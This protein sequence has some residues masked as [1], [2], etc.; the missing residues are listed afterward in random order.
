MTD[1]AAKQSTLN[2]V[3]L[4]AF[5]QLP[6]QIAQ[7]A[8]LQD[9]QL[10]TPEGLAHLLDYTEG[11]T[12]RN[13][14]QARQLAHF[15]ETVAAECAV[16][17][18]VPRAQYLRAQS[19]AINGE[20]TVALELVE[21]AHQGFLHLHLP[22]EALR[23]NI[24]RMR[25][26]GELGQ[27]G[28]AL[29]A[30]QQVLDWLNQTTSA[31]AV[32]PVAEAL[33][34]RALV[35]TQLGICYGQLGRFQ[36]ALTAFSETE[37]F[38]EALALPAH[39]AAA[40]NNRG[41][42]LVYLG[43]AREAQVAFV[44]AAQ[45]QADEG[46]TLPQAHTQSN[47]GEA[48][49]LLGDYR[50]ALAAFEQ[51]DRLLAN[52]D[53]LTDRQINWRQMADAYL[54]LNLFD[55]ALAT[56]RTIE[57]HL[58]QAGMV[59]ERAW[60]LWG[61]GAALAGQEQLTAAG[62]WLTAA[63]DAFAAVE[64]APLLAGV[65]LEQAAL[66]ERL[67]DNAGA[68]Q[69]AQQ[70]LDLVRAGQWPV[71][72]FLTHLRLADLAFPDVLA[73][74]EQLNAAQAL[75]AELA[76]PYLRH[77]LDQ[78]LARLY[79]LQGSTAE[80]LALL[81]TTVTSIETLRNTL[82]LEPMRLS[83][84]R[85]KLSVYELLVQL[86]LAQGDEE[87]VRRAFAV[88]ERARSRTLVERMAGLLATE[89][90]SAAAPAVADRLRTLQ[91]DLHAIYSRLLQQTVNE[92]ST[93]ERSASVA[94]LQASAIALEQEI[95]RLQLQVAPQVATP[96]ELTA[97]SVSANRFNAVGDDVVAGGIL[98][99]Y[100]LLEEEIIAFV[101]VDA[102]L[103]VVRGL[104][105]RTAVEARLQR[106]GMQWER[107]R[108]GSAFVQRHL[109]TLHQ[110]TQRILQELYQDL[111]APIATLLAAQLPAISQ[112]RA[113]TIVP[114]ALLYR[115]PFQALSDGQQTLLD[116]YV[117]AYAPS[118][119]ALLLLQQRQAVGSGPAVVVGVADPGIP[120]VHLEVQRV[121]AHLTEPAVQLDEA[122]TVPALLAQLP[123]VALLHLACHGIFR[124]DNPMFSALKL[125]DGW[126]TA[127]TVA[128]LRLRCA[129]VV[130]SA[131]E[132]GRGQSS[133]G[134]E[135]LGLARAFLGAGAA[136]LIVS[137]W[138]VQDATT[139]EL[140]DHFYG[141]L[142]AGHGAAVALRLA[143][144]AVKAHYPHPYYWA[145]FVLLGERSTG[146]AAYATP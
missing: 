8:A 137:Q 58:A 131:C 37:T 45:L 83:F 77:R 92:A 2:D 97:L 71:Q 21:A 49:L 73:V 20:L 143:Q 6:D 30:G 119:T 80:A 63:A 59:H 96:A 123:S 5:F 82:P 62:A 111:F 42:I 18:L 105:T 138:M 32:L 76:L 88:A 116:H 1:G 85:D 142:A 128:Q 67:G 81:E 99:A 27:F 23:T 101:L 57:P 29:V 39:N 146:L 33:T 145:P 74:T 95:N 70:A 41:L 47:L 132:S 66:L 14:G 140:M 55:E 90:T 139:A 60:V 52:Q 87:G 15:C 106:L 12:H 48:H 107:F 11:L 89:I 51:A 125:T 122:A 26:L 38:Y 110:S 72:Q 118:A 46:L 94:T 22:M 130:L 134:D 50:A 115:V 19:Y 102:Q 61:M 56:Y 109:A 68:R 113:L 98:V 127:A 144:L 36:E 91:A 79:L 93:A 40:K 69:A 112:P 75:A 126:L 13:P 103:H 43:R 44:A 9:A 136:T 133:G 24:G 64:N 78:R 84:L 4:T 121:A 129:L 25:V 114:H 135:L 104:G 16:P 10:L 108:A 117:I 124:A 86:Y 100:Y 31:A 34:L 3:W 120:A 17:A 28:A 35:Q 53:A 141:A 54:A 7:K 65:R